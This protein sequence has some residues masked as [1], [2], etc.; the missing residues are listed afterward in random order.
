MQENFKS[1][2]DYVNENSKHNVWKIQPLVDDFDNYKSRGFN[3]TGKY[4]AWTHG[5][6]WSNNLMFKYRAN[7]E[8][9]Y[10][11]LLDHQLG[12]D[13]TPVHDLSYLFYSGAS[14]AEFDKLDYY[15]IRVFQ[16]SLGEKQQN[17]IK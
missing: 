4:A 10:I 3:Y 5:D 12:R 14:K 7:G 9:E 17:V 6:C 1:A 13:S 2:L 16:N 15:T 8:L 11:K